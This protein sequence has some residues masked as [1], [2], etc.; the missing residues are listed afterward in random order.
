MANPNVT[1]TFSNGTTADASQVDTNFNDLINGAIDGTKDYNINALTCAGTATLNGAVNLGNGSVDDITVTGSLASSIPIKTTASYSIGAST[2]GLLAVYF[3]ANS[4]TVNL[5]GSGSMSATWTMTLPVTA[6]TVDYALLTDGNGVTSWSNLTTSLGDAAATRLGIK[7][8]KCDLS[9]GAND[10]AYNGGLKATVSLTAGGGTLSSVDLGLL[11]PYQVQD[12]SWRCRFN[13]HFILSSASRTAA[14][15]AINGFAASSVA[16][17]GI[18]AAPDN[19]GPVWNGLSEV[20]GT[21]LSQH[22]TSTTTNYSFS[23]DIALASKPTW[24][25]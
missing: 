1:Y 9:G 20:A 21:L 5:R 12:G 8:Y 25:Y 16:S 2:L 7:A 19:A 15:I 22:G 24:A 13:I 4:Q 14:R 17:Q 6:G 18:I 11:N 10:T 23:G 3:G